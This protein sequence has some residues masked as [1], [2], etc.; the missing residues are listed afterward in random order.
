MNF[1]CIFDGVALPIGTISLV[2]TL[3]VLLLDGRETVS[4]FSSI[5]S[6]SLF[7]ITSST[8][9]VSGSSG[10]LSFMSSDGSL[11]SFAVS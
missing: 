6:S 2:T 3:L 7:E 8:F 11:L 5:L 1:I 9:E 4:I 10:L